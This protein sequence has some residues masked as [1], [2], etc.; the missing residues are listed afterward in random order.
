MTTGR[1]SKSFYWMAHYILDIYKCN[2]KT[3]NMKIHKILNQTATLMEIILK[4]CGTLYLLAVLLFLLYPIYVY[5]SEGSLVM[6]LP[7][8]IP[9]VDPKSLNGYI[10]TTAFQCI[11]FGLA[12]FGITSSDGFF[13]MTVFNIP[14]MKNIIAIEVNQLNDLLTDDKPQVH[15]VKFKLKNIVLMSREM[16]T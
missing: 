12:Y 14:I 2:A 13:C 6:I 7:Y 16:K 4:T 8:T 11:A 5:C 3:E 9:A 1:H 10:I 15:A